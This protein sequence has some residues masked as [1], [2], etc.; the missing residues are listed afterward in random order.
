MPGLASPCCV[1]SV[2][3]RWGKQAFRICAASG[4]T[5]KPHSSADETLEK[6]GGLRAC[7][8]EAP[9]I[10]PPHHTNLTS[11]PA[12]VTEG[13][14]ADVKAASPVGRW[15]GASAPHVCQAISLALCS[16]GGATTLFYT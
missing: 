8:R 15:R 5:S 1:A 7:G 12:V 3:E 16:T 13:H 2:P 6:E 9:H 14:L 10:P 11:G 4:H